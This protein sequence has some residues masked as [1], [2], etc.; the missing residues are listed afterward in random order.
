MDLRDYLRIVRRRWLQIVTIMVVAASFQFLLVFTKPQM[1][2]SSME[3]FLRQ[4]PYDLG[5]MIQEEFP[6]PI[7]SLES[8]VLLLGSYKVCEETS[9]LMKKDHQYTLSA[10][11]VRGSMSVVQGK[12][13]ESVRVLFSHDIPDVTQWVLEAHY[14]AFVAY[15]VDSTTSEIK[16]ARKFLSER[17]DELKRTLADL[18]DRIQD[19]IY[20]GVID[21]K[22]QSDVKV[23]QLIDLERLRQ[24]NALDIRRVADQLAR[25]K[26]E[27]KDQ[28]QS[29]LL[30]QHLMTTPV[31]VEA[32][33]PAMGKT[34]KEL[35]ARLISLRKNYR[36]SHP[37]IIEIK[38]ELMEVAKAIREETYKP[39]EVRAIPLEAQIHLL[40]T[41][42]DF[43]KGLLADE[44]GELSKITEVS[45]MQGRFQKVTDKLEEL[46]LKIELLEAKR[47]DMVEM[48][49]P[50]S[51]PAKAPRTAE[52]TVPFI[53]LISAII[54]IAGGYIT[55]YLNDTIRTTADIRTYVNLQNIAVIPRLPVR[56]HHLLDLAVK[57]P[58][59]ELYNKL[60]AFLQSRMA[61][62][63]A[64]T[65][66]FTSTKPGEG[67]STIS[68]NVAAAMAQMGEKVILV[69][70]D[71]RKPQYHMI[72]SLDN[73]RGLS[74]ILSGE[75]EAEQTLH[76]I[77][78]GKGPVG[79]E[80]YLQQTS[81]ENLRVLTSGP[82]PMNPISLIKSERMLRLLADLRRIS[83]VVILDSPPVLMVV[84]APLLAAQ[85]DMTVLVIAENSVRRSEMALVKQSFHQVKA[86]VIG[87]ILNKAS[88]QAD[89]YYYYHQYRTYRA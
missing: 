2:T 29:D 37:T 55:E 47:H 81:L 10:D 1:Y 39:I 64:K 61:E 22:V 20:Q 32:A 63:K 42:D 89:T 84:D 78:N 68:A 57:S 25:L 60:A 15:E 79:V 43:L 53:V 44:W 48:V 86:N 45:N 3:L 51:V 70:T 27:E 73:S 76:E 33:D 71:L 7:I 4:S 6:F 24:Q 82:I 17:H 49:R 35:K 85:A 52:G 59:V 5:Y 80:S 83:D 77:T 23:Q 16:K 38:D 36:E 21:P 56:E 31:P 87:V 13:K 54:G 26:G 46:N 18:R 11:A 88:M 28:V 67:K 74:S 66:L 34:Y 14:A 62:Q 50:P 8:R 9:R 58:T 40:K 12:E 19:G 72:F 41:A 65:L 75:L 69:D 30:T